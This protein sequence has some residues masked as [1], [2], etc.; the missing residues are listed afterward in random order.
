MNALTAKFTTA[1]NWHAD[2]TPNRQMASVRSD[3][4]GWMEKTGL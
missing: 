4:S 1:K 3:K 2:Y